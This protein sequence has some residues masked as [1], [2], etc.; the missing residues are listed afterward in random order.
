VGG[1]ASRGGADGGDRAGGGAL[2]PRSSSDI[3]RRVPSSVW[4]TRR[5]RSP[6]SATF[7]SPIWPRE[8]RSERGFLEG[9]R[10]LLPRELLLERLAQRVLGTEEAVRRHEAVDALV[11]TEEVVVPKV[12]RETDA[13]VGE[14]GQR[15]ARQ[16]FDLDRLPQPLALAHRLRMVRARDHVLDPFALEEL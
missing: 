10:E 8:D 2:A 12:V 3:S 5:P 1:A 14:V 9:L 15:D 6:C 11:R 13:R 7:S 16:E 4:I